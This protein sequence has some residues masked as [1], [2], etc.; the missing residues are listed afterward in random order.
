MFVTARRPCD[1]CRRQ[2]KGCSK[3]D[4]GC[5]AC[6]VKG[7]ASS[8]HSSPKRRTETHILERV[9]TVCIYTFLFT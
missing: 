9:Q 2:K 6:K 3:D 5:V 4:G 8:F 1:E 7:M